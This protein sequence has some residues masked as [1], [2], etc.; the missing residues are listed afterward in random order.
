MI[1]PHEI[2]II[3]PTR[4]NPAKVSRLLNSIAS[5]DEHPGQ[6]LISESGKIGD[7]ILSDSA[8]AL[9]I[10]FLQ[11][12][13]AGQVLQRRYAYDFLSD[14]I[15]VV[16][17]FDDDITLEKGLSGHSGTNGTSILKPKEQNWA[18]CPLMSLICLK[19]KNH[20]SENLR[21]CHLCHPVKLPDPDI[22]KATCP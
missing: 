16:V 2:A 11:A 18:A 7:N 9:N 15:K 6:V 14:H 13:V 1:L 19:S 8:S 22:Q 4:N 5:Q 21:S 3:C 10:T 12:P 20:G 17:H